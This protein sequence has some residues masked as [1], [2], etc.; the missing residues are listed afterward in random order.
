MK[1][2]FSFALLLALML[3]IFSLSFADTVQVGDGTAY[4]SV[5]PIYGYYHYSYT[6]QIYTQAQ[7]NH[8]GQSINPLLL[9][10]R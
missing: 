3:S 9:Q 10:R 7:I 6:Q 8:A 2:Y 5:L 4:S 1:R